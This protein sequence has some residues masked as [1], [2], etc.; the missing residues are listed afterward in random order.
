MK[1][2][3]GRRHHLPRGQFSIRMIRSPSLGGDRPRLP[4]RLEPSR[5]PSHLAGICPGLRIT[6]LKRTHSLSVFS[7]LQ[8]VHNIQFQS[9]HGADQHAS[10]RSG[11]PRWWQM[12]AQPQR[13]A[14]QAEDCHTCWLCFPETFSWSSLLFCMSSASLYQ[15]WV[16]PHDRLSPWPSEIWVLLREWCWHWCPLLDW[17]WSAGEL[18]VS[19]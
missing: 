12:L 4:D 17:R 1:L 5:S 13:K 2:E 15:I 16:S 11:L 10:T 7:V 6:Q 14:C 9:D 8:N 19:R 3:L 18:K